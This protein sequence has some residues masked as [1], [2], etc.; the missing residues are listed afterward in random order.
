MLGNWVEGLP[1]IVSSLLLKAALEHNVGV[2][3]TP[4]VL[5]VASLEGTVRKECKECPCEPAN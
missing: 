1:S 2:K 3:L 5:P 4:G